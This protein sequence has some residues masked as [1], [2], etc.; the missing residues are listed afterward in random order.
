MKSKEE[1]NALKEEVEILNKKLHELTDEELAQVTG[2]GPGSN[3]GFGR[4]NCPFCNI[5]HDVYSPGPFI[6]NRLTYVC[7]TCGGLLDAGG[8][9]LKPPKH[10][11]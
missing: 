11:N 4:F 9:P 2:G 7:E 5:W 6:N 1:L 3:F 8:L 10:L